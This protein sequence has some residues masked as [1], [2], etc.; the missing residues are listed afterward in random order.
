MSAVDE[1]AL[2]AGVDTEAGRIERR[3]SILALLVHTVKVEIEIGPAVS[4]KETFLLCRLHHALERFDACLFGSLTLPHEL[5]H[6]VSAADLDIR[7]ASAGGTGSAD[8]VVYVEPRADDRGIS[9]AS[10]DLPGET[11]G[12][13]RSRN[14]PVGVHR[15]AVDRAVMLD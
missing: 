8:L 10:R 2:L 12:R 7:L 1:L 4:S 5:H 6:R 3:P 13:S 9:D 15:Q 11:A 14:I